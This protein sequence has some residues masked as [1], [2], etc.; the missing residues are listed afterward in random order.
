MAN[1]NMKYETMLKK[2]KNTIFLFLYTVLL[3][4]KHFVEFYVIA[5]PSFSDWIVR[6]WG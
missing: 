3:Y 1:V 2:K 6:I 4:F 5:N